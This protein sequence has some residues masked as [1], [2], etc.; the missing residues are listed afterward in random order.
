MS[1]FLF[2]VRCVLAAVWVYHGLWLKLVVRDTHHLEIVGAVVGGTGIS[3]IVGLG[4]IGS[5]ETLLALGI[6]SGLWPRF[7][8]SF[9]IG[10]LVLMNGCGILFGGGAIERPL[11]LVIANLPLVACAAM[12]IVFGPGRLALGRH[13]GA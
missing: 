10:L 12:V 4:I 11:G 6:M 1:W 2:A 7:V 13:A 3:P 9:Q 8:N 5:G